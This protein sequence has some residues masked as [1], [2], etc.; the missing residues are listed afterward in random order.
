MSAFEQTACLAETQFGAP[1]S[2][3][4][5]HLPRW[6]MD[7]KFAQQFR[8]AS[9][10]GV[11]HRGLTPDQRTQAIRRAM[12]DDEDRERDAACPLRKVGDTYVCLPRGDLY[13]H[14]IG[15]VPA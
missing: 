14:T 7:A 9:A 12:M 13:W 10:L 4:A 8:R 2:L 6:L 3:W 15:G 11:E 1:A 5:E